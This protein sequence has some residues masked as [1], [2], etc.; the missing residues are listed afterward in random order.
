[1]SLLG[2]TVSILGGGFIGLIFVADLLV[3]SSACRA[4]VW[5]WAPGII[6]CSLLAGGL[7][8]LVRSLRSQ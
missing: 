2:T 7:G 6:A 8:S 4:S 5:D 1:M 3:E